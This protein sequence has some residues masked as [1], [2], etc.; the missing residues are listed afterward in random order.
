MD[1]IID[2]EPPMGP[3]VEPSDRI[4]VIEESVIED[5]DDDTIL[6]EN[7]EQSRASWTD[8]ANPPGTIP[9]NLPSDPTTIDHPGN[10]EGVS[11]DPI[12]LRPEV[13]LGPA[14]QLGHPE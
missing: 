12:P 9:P 4:P 7:R 10:S 13:A 11:S 3:P 6:P 14:K 2:D 5:L 8:E 1:T